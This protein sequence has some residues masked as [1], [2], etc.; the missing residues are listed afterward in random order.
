M[1]NSYL[2]FS[3]HTLHKLDGHTDYVYS[4]SGRRWLALSCKYILIILKSSLMLTWSGTRNFVLS[5]TRSCFSA[6]Y[7]SIITKILVGCCSRIS[8]TSS[9]LCSAKKGRNTGIIEGQKSNLFS[10]LVDFHIWTHL[11]LAVA[12]QSSKNSFPRTERNQTRT[13]HIS[14]RSVCK[15]NIQRL[16]AFLYI[17][18]ELSV[19]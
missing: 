17:N 12:E 19:R 8:R 4:V 5:R 16:V 7:F 18:N 6:L 1:K 2:S 11:S 15:I 13:P 14:Q 9:T 3:L 10:A